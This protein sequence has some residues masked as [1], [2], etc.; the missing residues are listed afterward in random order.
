MTKTYKGIWYHVSDRKCKKVYHKAVRRA[1][2][3]KGV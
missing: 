3:V 1:N 2:K